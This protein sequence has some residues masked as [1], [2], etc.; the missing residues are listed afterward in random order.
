MGSDFPGDSSLKRT[1]AISLGAVLNQFEL[2]NTED[3]S[4]GRAGK[5]LYRGE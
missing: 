4:E 3:E 1:S 2:F 5:Q